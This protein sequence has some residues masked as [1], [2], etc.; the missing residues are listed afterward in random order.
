MVIVRI[1]AIVKTKIMALV[2]LI[3]VVKAIIF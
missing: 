1:M 3:P 2:R